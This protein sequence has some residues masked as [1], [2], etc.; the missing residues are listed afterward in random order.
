LWIFLYYNYKYFYKNILNNL[1]N[2]TTLIKPQ[3]KTSIPISQYKVIN[4]MASI[5]T[6][7]PFI[8][9]NSDSGANS[10]NKS[11]GCS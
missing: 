2:T 9:L 7:P 3:K 8:N 5:R 6:L 4:K 11:I 1:S 10:Q